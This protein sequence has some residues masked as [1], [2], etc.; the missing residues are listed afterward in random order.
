MSTLP[1]SVR[2]RRV[3]VKRRHSADTSASIAPP[4]PLGRPY[5]AGAP[6]REDD[7]FR[8]YS[9]TKPFTSVA[10]LM[11]RDD[12]KLDPNDPMSK[13]LPQPQSSRWAWRRR[14]MPAR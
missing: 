7:I 10:I 8:I 11:L 4:S 12:G 14:T 1:G 5:A 13:Y 3:T 6:L 2:P 9:M